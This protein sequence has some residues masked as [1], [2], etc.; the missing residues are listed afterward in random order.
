MKVRKEELSVRS[1]AD[2]RFASLA[3]VRRHSIATQFVGGI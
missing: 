3:F 2:T 1:V